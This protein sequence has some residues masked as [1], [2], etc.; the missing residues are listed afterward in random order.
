MSLTR[1]L[2]KLGAIFRKNDID[3]ELDIYRWTEDLGKDIRFGLRMLFKNRGFSAV[4]VIS[5]ALGF[6]L[7]TTI[8]TVVNAILLNPLPVRDVSRL[9]QLDTVDAK[10]KVTQAN[11]TKLGMS[12]PN[13]EDYRRHE[14]FH[15]RI[16]IQTSDLNPD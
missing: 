9:V 2:V 15:P 5:L 3:R 6:G 13:F 4:A 11:A 14:V 12:F 1:G 8:F 16:C 10:T 7:K